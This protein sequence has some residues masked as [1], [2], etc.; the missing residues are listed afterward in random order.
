MKKNLIKSFLKLR[1]KPNCAVFEDQSIGPVL[2][3]YLNREKINNFCND[4]NNV[5]KCYIN[6]LK[7][8]VIF[9]FYLDSSFFFIIK[10]PRLSEIIKLVLN[11][12]SLYKINIENF[13]YL[14]EFYDLIF[15]KYYFFLKNSKYNNFLL[16]KFLFNSLFS[17]KNILIKNEYFE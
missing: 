2:S 3:E 15:F 10:G 5:S 6:D 14:T 7:L 16:K 12:N 17:I 1:I 8:S 13:L 11:I 9:Y 4:F